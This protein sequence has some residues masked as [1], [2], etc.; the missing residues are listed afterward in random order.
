MTLYHYERINLRRV[1]GYAVIIFI[2]VAC[3]LKEAQGNPSAQQVVPEIPY[4]VDGVVYYPLKNVDNFGE[5]GIASWYG[6]SF[7]GQL[8]S[9]KEVYDMNGMTAAHKTL[10]FNT[11]VQVI[12][13]DNGTEAVVRINDRGPFSKHRIIDLSYKAAKKLRLV[14]KGTANVRL[15]ALPNENKVTDTNNEHSESYTIQV[16]VFKN[17]NNAN[18]IGEKLENSK[19]KPFNQDG[20][21]YYRVIVGNFVAFDDALKTRNEVRKQGYPKAY[22]ILN[23]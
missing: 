23:N 21:L 15:I 5:E 6:S 1:L 18:R 12:N 17:P 14:G 10:P 3:I 22:I 7:H 19:V 13:L 16:A 20:A 2:S 9:S 8:T 4:Q 11:L